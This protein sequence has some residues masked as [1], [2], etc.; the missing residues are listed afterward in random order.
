MPININ[1]NAKLVGNVYK[2]L[3]KNP[4]ID[5]ILHITVFLWS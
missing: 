4:H 1:I 3:N 2:V 5:A